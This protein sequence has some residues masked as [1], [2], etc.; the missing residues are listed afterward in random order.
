MSRRR[1]PTQ[2]WRWG[3]PITPDPRDRLSQPRTSSSGR[4][5]KSCRNRQ[6]QMF[7]SD[8]DSDHGDEPQASSSAFADRIHSD[9]TQLGDHFRV[10]EKRRRSVRGAAHTRQRRKRGA[11]GRPSHPFDAE[12]VEFVGPDAGGQAGTSCRPGLLRSA[13]TAQ[14]VL[15]VPAILS[16]SPVCFPNCT[17]LLSGARH[18]DKG[19]VCPSRRHSASKPQPSQGWGHPAVR[20]AAGRPRPSGINDWA[21]SG[22]AP[23][24][25]WRCD[26]VQPNGSPDGSDG[27]R[28]HAAERAAQ[29]PPGVAAA[30]AALPPEPA[31]GPVAAAG[32]A[33]R[34]RPNQ[35]R[36]RQSLRTVKM[37]SS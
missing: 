1:R 37:I 4:S 27:R 30:G 7:G 32:A 14:S 10:N 8:A 6:A 18:H 26:A 34:R 28:P 24:R 25:L 21:R 20:Q 23:T 29:Q 22:P 12:F 2:P 11:V 36:Q 33:K 35:E 9:G 3:G 15:A 13:S 17:A 31:A 5:S 16:G 19:A